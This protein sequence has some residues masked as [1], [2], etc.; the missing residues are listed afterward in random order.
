MQAEFIVC[1]EIA[2]QTIWLRN[3]I[4]WLRI[5]YST[6]RPLTI[7]YDNGAVMFFIK[8]N[9]CS[10]G[11]KYLELKYLIIKDLVKKGDITVEHI[12]IEF[13]LADLLTKALRPMC[14]T[15]LVE[16]MGILNSFDVLG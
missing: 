2:A 5:I 3:H 4:A 10:S 11:S 16:N 8:N 12:N 1:Y 15:R 6:T 13:M 9:K 14:F 7:Y